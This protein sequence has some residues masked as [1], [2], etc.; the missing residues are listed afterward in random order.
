MRTPSFPPLR[1]DRPGCFRKLG[2]FCRPHY[3]PGTPLSSVNRRFVP[4]E[5]ADEYQLRLTE[6]A[7]I[8]RV[9]GALQFSGEPNRSTVKTQLKC[10]RGTGRPFATSLLWIS[11]TV[12]RTG[13]RTL[14][15]CPVE[16]FV[17][18]DLRTTPSTSV[19]RGVRRPYI[20]VAPTRD[21]PPSR[22]HREHTFRNFR[23]I[24]QFRTPSRLC[25]P[26][27]RFI[28]ML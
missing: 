3:T 16:T 21:Q 9:K 13:R 14:S 27:L 5:C 8:C 7:A 15:P 22:N 12:L 2:R 17:D 19:C 24:A 25:T 28:R 11:R 20:V 23:S 26:L 4:N 10:L 6:E 1:T 18:G